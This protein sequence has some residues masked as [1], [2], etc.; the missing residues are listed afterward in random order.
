MI[1]INLENGQLLFI[2]LKYESFVC[3]NHNK[4]CLLLNEK[5]QFSCICFLQNIVGLSR[6][7]NPGPL[8]PKARII[9]LD[10]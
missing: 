5:K 2:R 8:A 10:H 9:P 1:H 3:Y 7:L 4:T 6:D